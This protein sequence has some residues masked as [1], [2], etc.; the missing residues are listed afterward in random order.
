MQ[1]DQDFIQSVIPSASVLCGVF[2]ENPR[3]T[4]DSRI[5]E[6]GDIFVALKGSRC[7]GHDFIHDALFNGAAGIIIAT[8]HID[9]IATIK[10]RSN[11]WILVVADPYN[12][13]IALAMK[14]RSLFTGH[15]IGITGSVGKT[16]T[17]EIVAHIFNHAGFSI[18]ASRGNQN[19]QLGIA[20]NILL[21]RPEHRFAVLEAGIS[22]R[23][24]MAELVKLMQPT[25]AIITN[26]GH[27]HMEGL[28]SLHDIAL[29]KREIFKY[30]SEHN[31]GIINGDQPILSQ[32]SYKHP[33]I[34]CG[35]KTTNQIQARKVHV[36]SDRISCV[37][38]IYRDKYPLVVHHANSGMISNILAATAVAHLLE[39]P[40]EAIL[41]SIA[42]PRSLKGRFERCMIPRSH[43]VIIDDSYNANPESMKAAL[44]AFHRVDTHIHKIAILGEMCELGIS[45]PFWHRQLGRFLK[46]VPS[47]KYVVLV[48]SMTKWVKKT[49]PLGLEIDMV[50]SWEEAIPLVVKHVTQKSL[51]FVK[52]SLTTNVSLIVDH[53]LEKKNASI[54]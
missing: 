19:T 26:I 10:N 9:R 51:I 7:D 12:A 44:L 13:L 23:G 42:Q 47:L 15:V 32:V 39:V 16:S 31:I 33:I 18:Y 53:L 8:E 45:S 20:L 46:K 49:A 4:V 43:S 41:S 3:F 17:K 35:L 54:T 2:P 22:K 40:R 30:F 21:I 6:P 36:A 48:G 5:T 1:F 37:L 52:G 11:V 28:G 24:E 38:K 34:K 50:A 29:E 14:W 27:A 25:T